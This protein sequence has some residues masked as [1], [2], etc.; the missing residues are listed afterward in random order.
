MTIELELQLATT[1]KTLPHPSQF[2]EWVSI[3]LSDQLNHLKKS[4]NVELTIRIVD[5]PEITYLNNRYR[6]KE[7]STNVLSFPVQL[8]KEINYNLLGDIHGQY[9]DL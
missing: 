3:I 1:A 7:G 8:E 5:E 2:K 6:D 4:N 9:Y